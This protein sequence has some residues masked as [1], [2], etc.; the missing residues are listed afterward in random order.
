MNS[1]TDYDKEASWYTFPE[2]LEDAN[3][4]WRIYQNEISLD[5]GLEGE[6][7]AW[8]SNFT[9]NPIEWFTQ[10]RVRFRPPAATIFR[11][12]SRRRRRESRRKSASWRRTASRP[13][14]ER[15]SRVSSRVCESAS[16]TRRPSG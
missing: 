3:V 16:R 2:R 1:D 12:S 14:P 9:D 10:Y 4:S 11:H 13:M 6:Q 5:T 7:D 8:L 15:R